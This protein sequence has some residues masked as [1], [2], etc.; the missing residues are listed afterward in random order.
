[1]AFWSHQDAIRKILVSLY[2]PQIGE[3][4]D[5]R[6]EPADRVR[7]VDD[8]LSIRSR[9]PKLA[10][11]RPMVEAYG[12]PP[13]PTTVCLRKPRPASRPIFRRRSVRAS[14]VAHLTAVN[15]DVRR[16][17][18]WRPWDAMR[19]PVG[20]ASQRCSTPR[21][22]SAPSSNAPAQSSTDRSDG[23]ANRATDRLVPPLTGRFTAAPSLSPS[24]R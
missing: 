14:S 10:M 11:P 8:L 16:R 6:L 9:F 20:S 21:S 13:R 1:M 19:S 7:I 4:S 22:G 23:S 15:A 24:S 17:R 3:I 12:R 2:T 18:V 5:E